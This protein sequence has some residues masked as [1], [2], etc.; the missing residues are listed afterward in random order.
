MM[1]NRF[2][3]NKKGIELHVNTLVIVILSLFILILSFVLYK[4]VISKSMEM[5]DQLN[6][7]IKKRI[8][9]IVLE[10]E[11]SL[12]Y[13]PFNFVVLKGTGVANFGYA[14]KNEKNDCTKFKIFAEYL[15]AYDYQ[16]NV[17]SDGN[18][19]VIIDPKY[20]VSTGG[21]ELE[22]KKNEIEIKNLAISFKGSKKGVY[23]FRV[24]ATDCSG[25]N[26]GLPKYLFIVVK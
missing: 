9:K 5:S 15:V 21:Y 4:T 23:V 20:A 19:Q 13:V 1:I 18:T 8:E 14:L 26:Y 24:N 16:K 12:F 7:E 22:V 17:I 2:N 10:S 3:V 6:L 25:E 11:Q